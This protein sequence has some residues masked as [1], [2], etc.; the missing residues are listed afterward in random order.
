MSGAYRDDRERAQ[1]RI[2]ELNRE[3]TKHRARMTAISETRKI[4]ERITDRRKI[5]AILLITLLALTGLFVPLLGSD[6]LWPKLLVG[7]PLALGTLWVL[8]RYGEPI[9]SSTNDEEDQNQTTIRLRVV[10]AKRIQLDEDRMREIEEE[11]R[12][13]TAIHEEIDQMKRLIEP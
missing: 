10:E 11:Q 12:I 3:L 2:G 7:A 8:F 1:A 13:C 5:P 9:G 6:A 4:A